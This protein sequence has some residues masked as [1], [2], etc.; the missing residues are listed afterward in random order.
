MRVWKEQGGDAVTISWCCKSCSF[1]TLAVLKQWCERAQSREPLLPVAQWLLV[2]GTVE[3]CCFSAVNIL[4]R[5]Q[6]ETWGRGRTGLRSIRE[7]SLHYRHIYVI[8]GSVL[9]HRN[10]K[11]SQSPAAS[12]TTLKQEKMQAGCKLDFGQNIRS[13]HFYGE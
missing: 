3:Q 2:P 11:S 5:W 13:S 10:D 6:M 8:Q 7:H 4:S 1:F 12:C 9:Q